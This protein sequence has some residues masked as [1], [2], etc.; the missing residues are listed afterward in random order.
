M[1]MVAGCTQL[2]NASASK[3]Q[4]ATRLP[5]EAS[6]GRR[7]ILSGPPSRITASNPLGQPHVPAGS[8]IVNPTAAGAAANSVMGRQT[9][10]AIRPP[11]EV[12]NGTR[13]LPSRRP[14]TITGAN[15]VEQPHADTSSDIVNPTAAGATAAELTRHQDQTGNHFRTPVLLLWS[16]TCV[17]PRATIPRPPASLPGP[18][19]FPGFCFPRMLKPSVELASRRPKPART[20]AKAGDSS[21]SSSPFNLQRIRFDRR[22]SRRRWGR[23]GIPTFRGFFTAGVGKSGCDIRSAFPPSS[24]GS[25]RRVSPGSARIGRILAKNDSSSRTSPRFVSDIG[26]FAADLRGRGVIHRQSTTWPPTDVF[27]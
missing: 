7:R 3:D 5:S 8:D 25:N 21:G 24:V 17:L 16:S 14:S 6:N 27:S 4:I 2:S 18:D 11:I 9:Q 10:I 1:Y 20:R 13:R 23:A 12:S 26:P 19:I 15:P 22:V